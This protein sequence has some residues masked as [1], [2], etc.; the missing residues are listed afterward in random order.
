MNKLNVLS[1][2]ITLLLKHRYRLCD[3]VNAK[4]ELNNTHTESNF[5]LFIKITRKI[6]LKLESK[7]AKKKE[8]EK[9]R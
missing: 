3:L 8:K 9:A 1:K 4:S 5:P 2:L 6:I 7:N